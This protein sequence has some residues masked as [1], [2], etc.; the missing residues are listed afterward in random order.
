MIGINLIPD[1]KQELLR[2]QRQRNSFVS[3]AIVVAGAAVAVVLLLGLLLGGQA[4]ADNNLNGDIKKYNQELQGI[5]N[6]SSVLTI[7]NQVGAI[8]ELNGSKHMTSRMYETIAAILPPSPNDI[9]ISRFAIDPAAKTITIEGQAGKDFAAL[10]VFQKTITA[11]EVS[12]TENGEAK[13][14]PLTSAVA[15]LD[16]G[17]GDSSTGAKVLTFAISFVYPEQLFSQQAKNVTVKGPNS[18]DATDSKRSVPDSL[19]TRPTATEGGRG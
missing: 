10:D 17:Y 9:K 19:F 6:L 7:Q 11:A 18:Q 1:V 12:Y 13:T 15:I 14:V 16:Q 8:S 4:I 2:A 5:E 3:I